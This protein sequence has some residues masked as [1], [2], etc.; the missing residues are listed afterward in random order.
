MRVMLV[1]DDAI[2]RDIM[3]AAL[4]S[5]GIQVTSVATGDEAVALLDGGFCPD[6]L[7]TDIRLPGNCDGW[8]VA[9][10]YKDELPGL[11]VI[12]VTA[13][14]T[15]TDQVDNSVYLRKPISPK[16]LL[17]TVRVMAKPPLGRSSPLR[18]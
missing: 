5:G 13:S 3:G 11:P 14:R 17:A 9:R 6:L 2:N 12:Y 8:L 7:L 18:H 10:I 1:E 16:L 4:A 15:A